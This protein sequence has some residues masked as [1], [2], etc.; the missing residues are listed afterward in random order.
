V[1]YLKWKRKKYRTRKNDL[2]NIEN[3][4]ETLNLRNNSFGIQGKLN[5]LLIWK[6]TV[7]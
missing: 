4:D 1:N 6:Y 2:G 5:S 3:I 7:R